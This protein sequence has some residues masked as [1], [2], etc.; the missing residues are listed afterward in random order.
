MFGGSTPYTF[1]L[2]DGALPSGMK[3]SADGVLGGV[4]ATAGTYLFTVGITDANGVSITQSFRLVV[5][6]AP[7]TVTKKKPTKKKPKSRNL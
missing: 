1:S 2:L 6:K 4:P 3:L 7:P 5:E